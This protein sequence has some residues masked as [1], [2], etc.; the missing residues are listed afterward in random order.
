MTTDSS[1]K[2]RLMQTRR[3]TCEGF[4]RDD[5]LFEI[6]S[7]L[8][9]FKPYAVVVGDRGRIEA[10]EPFHQMRL[11]LVIDTELNIR[12]AAAATLHAPYAGCTDIN[13]AYAGLAGLNLGPGFMKHVRDRFGGKAG[14]THLTELLGPAVTTAMQTVWHVRDQLSLPKAL[15]RQPLE[16]V[17]ERPPEVDRCH[18][19]RIDGDTVR[20]HYPG[21]HAGALVR[22]SV[23]P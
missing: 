2:R 14:C 21:F 17:N 7:V 4:Q 13:A 5:G 16:D 12:E 3:I 9:D 10:G 20:K 6:E 11:R 18:A 19:L 8:I 15:R 1:E 23:D 22:S